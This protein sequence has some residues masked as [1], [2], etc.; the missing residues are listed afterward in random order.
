MY[1]CAFVRCQHR[2]VTLEILGHGRYVYNIPRVLDIVRVLLSGHLS[3]IATVCPNASKMPWKYRKINHI[4]TL[5]AY[6]YEHPII[7]MKSLYISI[8]VILQGYSCFVGGRSFGIWCRGSAMCVSVQ[9]LSNCVN[10]MKHD[11]FFVIWICADSN[12]LH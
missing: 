12:Y 5:K 11:L 9:L 2:V 3:T 1:K 10:K 8:K 7:L 4:N 6:D